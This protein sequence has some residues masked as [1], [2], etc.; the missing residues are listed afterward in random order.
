ME[1]AWVEARFHDIE[2]NYKIIKDKIAEAAIKSGRNPS[3]VRLMG[4]TKTV[5]SIYINHAL[6]LGVDLI[7][8]NRVQEFLGKRDELK[9]DGVE[10]HL[11]GHL[12]TNKVRQIVGEVD[13]IDSVDSV[14]V[15][16]EIGKQSLKRG[17]IT[18]VLVEINIGGED[19]KFGIDPSAILDN[20][21]QMSEIDGIRINGL[22]AIPP[23]CDDD[24]ENCKFF[25]NMYG[26]FLDIRAK[27]LDNVNMNILSM[28]MSGDFE[29]AVREGSTMVRVGSSLF[30]RRVY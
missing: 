15:A 29:N 17:I 20:I 11:I 26:M 24:K 14:K 4:V 1:K 6:D 5:E 3:D 21:Y 7:G 13:M 23:I 22:M 10:K 19:S 28:G 27:K 25:A 30:G 16:A 8:E 12:Q 18:D 9:L 2:E